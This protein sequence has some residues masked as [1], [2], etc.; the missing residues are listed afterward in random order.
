MTKPASQPGT[1]A[2][3]P[4]KRQ[5]VQRQ[6]LPVFQLVRLFRWVLVIGFGGVVLAVLLLVCRGLGVPGDRCRRWVPVLWV[7][8]AAPA[9]APAGRGGLKLQT[10]GQRKPRPL[11]CAENLP[12]NRFG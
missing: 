11:S 7:A 5:H 8:S 2:A 3:R 10:F 9:G 6:R 4:A 12:R 1:P